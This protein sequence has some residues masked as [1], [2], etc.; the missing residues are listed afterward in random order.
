MSIYANDWY[1]NQLCDP[2]AALRLHDIGATL[3]GSLRRNHTFFFLSYE[4]MRLYQP[5]VWRQPVP[6]GDARDNSPSWA[7]P[8]LNLFP[9]ANGGPLGKG[10]AEW[11]G[12]ISR[13]SCRAAR[14]W[15]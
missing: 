10:L 6:T 9:E 13:P 11:T 12:R 8:V 14:A 5:F 15:A 2:R 7:Q 3:G 4:A 1:A